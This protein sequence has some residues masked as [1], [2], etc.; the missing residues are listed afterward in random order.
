MVSV[1]ICT[2]NDLQNDLGHTLLWRHDVDRHLASRLDEARMMAL[3]ARPNV[4]VVDRDL[5]WAARLVSALREEPSTRGLSIVVVA[6]GDFDPG[7][8]ELLEAGANAILRLPVDEGGDGR[9]QRL[10]DVPARKDARFSVSFR[11]DAYTAGAPGP[12]PA[13]ALNLSRSGLLMEASSSLDVGDRLELQFVPGEEPPPV[14]V[15]GRVVRLAS[16]SR[17]GIEFTDLEADV[18]DRL[19]RFLDRLEQD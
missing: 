6:R 19:L 1:L 15:R 3:A 4:V 16:P 13:L 18:S 9:L 2:H 10:V 5:P 11:V 17:Y 12:E 14:R 7:E 8:V